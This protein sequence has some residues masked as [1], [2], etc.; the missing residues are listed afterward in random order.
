MKRRTFLKGTIA[1]SIAGAAVS[2]GLLTPRLVLAEWPK[3]SFDAT[4]VTE[5]L[6]SLLGSDS[7]SPNSGIQIKAPDIAENG[8]VVPITVTSSLP[9]IESITVIVEK[10]PSPLAANFRLASNTEGFVSTRVKMGKTSDLIAVVKS[11]GK[12]HSAKKT[13]KVTIGGCGG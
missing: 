8:A 13:V 11:G 6:S 3:A 1:S 10:N 7:H 4:S 5:S 9:N 2:A 12:L